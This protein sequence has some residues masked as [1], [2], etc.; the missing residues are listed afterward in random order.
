MVPRKRGINEAIRRQPKRRKVRIERPL[1][2]QRPNQLST[3][4]SIARTNALNPASIEVRTIEQKSLVAVPSRTELALSGA[5]TVAATEP[6][7]WHVS[8]AVGCAINDVSDIQ[9]KSA[10]RTNTHDVSRP[11]ID[12]GVVEATMRVG[13]NQPEVGQDHRN[14]NMLPKAVAQI[15]TWEELHGSKSKRS[16]I[17]GCIGETEIDADTPTHMHMMP[18]SGVSGSVDYLI[19]PFKCVSSYILSILR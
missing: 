4:N 14:L 11:A 15:V 18:T 3:S 6:V 10:I 1:R 8:T 17:E 9:L 16:N 13:L 19:R 2:R 7:F 12:P 5:L